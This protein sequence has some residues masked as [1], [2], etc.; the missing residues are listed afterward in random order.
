MPKFYEIHDSLLQALDQDGD[1]VSIQLRALLA[2]V[3]EGRQQAPEYLR[4]DIRLVCEGAE[5]T[6]DSLN[7][8]SWLMEGSFRAEEQDSES[9]G[10]GVKGR[11]PALLRSARGV[12][13]VLAG[14]HEESGDFVTIR[15][16]ANSLR[17]EQLGE[18]QSM[19]YTRATI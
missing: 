12:E 5:L 1:R 16:R 6:V 2:K 10:E 9:T 19:Q 4:Q 13:L 8:P 3:E 18:P 14:L 15:V 17:L 11:I 7:L